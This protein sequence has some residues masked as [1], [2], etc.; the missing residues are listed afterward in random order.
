MSN[1]SDE[2]TDSPLRADYHNFHTVEKWT[3]DGAKI[4]RPFT[5]A[6]ISRRLVSC[7]PKQSNTGRG[8]DWPS[9]SGRERLAKPAELHPFNELPTRRLISERQ[10]GVYSYPGQRH[11]FSRH[12]GAHFNAAAAALANGRTSEFVHQQLR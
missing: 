5:Q 1:W 6:T 2:E 7:S 3:K 10:C 12:N 9:G 8:S 4:E 11:A